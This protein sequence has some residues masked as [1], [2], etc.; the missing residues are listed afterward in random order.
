VTDKPDLVARRL[1]Y[2]KRQIAL[3]KGVDV[4]FR[5]QPP[6]GSGQAN[7]HGM[8][9]LPIGQHEVKNWPVLDLGEQPHVALKDWK[10]EVSGLVAHPLTLKWDDFLALPQVEDVSDFH[11]VTTWSRFDNHWKGVR[12]RT[13][14]ELAVPLPDAAYVLCTSYDFAPGTYIPYTT[15]LPLA[16]ATEDDVLLVHTWEGVPLPPEHGGPCRMIT[17]K[18]YAWKGAKWIRKIE[19][20]ADDR[21]GFWEERGYSNTAEPWFNDRYSTD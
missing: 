13:I 3:D 21:R 10:L 1:E 8:P 18:L 19:F 16:R 17:P 15:N 4:R 12:F 6:R 14:A 20:L 9:R 11:C 5:G 2:I 7:R